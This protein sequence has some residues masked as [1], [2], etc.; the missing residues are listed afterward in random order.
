MYTHL[1][2]DHVRKVLRLFNPLNPER[3][4]VEEVVASRRH[5]LMFIKDRTN[6][7]HRR[8]ISALG[9]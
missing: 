6:Y 5:A 1:S 2:N 3:L 8:A 4:S 9:G 7:H